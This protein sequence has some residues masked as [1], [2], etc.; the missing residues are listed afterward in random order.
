MTGMTLNCNSNTATRDE[1]EIFLSNRVSTVS[2]PAEGRFRTQ[3]MPAKKI[4]DIQER[5]GAIDSSIDEV[6]AEH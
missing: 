4:L 2:T 1:P 3:G 6:G 5:G